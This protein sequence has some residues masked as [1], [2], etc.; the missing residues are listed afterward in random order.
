MISLG[1][2]LKYLRIEK[3]LTQEE[4]AENLNKKFEISINKGMISKWESDKSEP[5]LDYTKNLAEYFDVSLDY[6]IGVS[7]EKGAWGKGIQD[8][9]S[10]MDI[11]TKAAHKV[12]HEGPLSDE[13]KDKIALAIQIALAKHKNSR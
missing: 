9:L 8:D 7:K 13:E 10:E 4:L 12:G 3:G 2:R 11:F 5:R 6:L 1:S